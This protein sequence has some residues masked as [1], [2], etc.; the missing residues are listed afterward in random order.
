VF[1][2]NQALRD[3]LPALETAIAV[4]VGIF[5]FVALVGAGMVAAWSFALYFWLIQSLSPSLSALIVGFVLLLLSTIAVLFGRA[6]TR[7]SFD[8]DST[9]KPKSD[10][11][12]ESLTKAIESIGGMAETRPIPALI[13]ALALGL[14]AGYF[15]SGERTQR[16]R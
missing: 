5:G 2:I 8:M 1:G 11:S 13:G 9:P 12:Q 3:T 7:A 16:P 14:A 6:A 10:G 4:M 15:E